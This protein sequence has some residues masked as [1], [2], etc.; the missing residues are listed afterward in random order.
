MLMPQAKYQFNKGGFTIIELI[1][2]IA[3]FSVAITLGVTAVISVMY[4]NRS[5]QASNLA[6]SN[7]SLAIEAMN[8]SIRVGYS[9][10]LSSDSLTYIPAN[11]IG[12]ITYEY[13]ADAK[14]IVRTIDDPDNGQSVNTVT[15]PEVIIEELRFQ[16]QSVSGEQPKVLILI[17][18]RS[19]ANDAQSGLFY[20]QSMV[21]QRLIETI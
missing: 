7:L 19:S 9:Y 17:K 1:V 10:Q 14:S 16:L 5:S 3:V 4:A 8:R 21:S 20:M 6:M 11:G 18:G 12:T 2:S 13:D 15:A